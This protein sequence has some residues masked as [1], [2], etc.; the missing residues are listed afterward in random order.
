MADFV[1][2]RT[3]LEARGF[4]VEEFHTVA[5][6]KEHLQQTITQKTVAFGGSVG[7]TDMGLYEAL[8]PNN[9]VYW[10]AL[11]GPEVLK[12]AMSTN[13]YI[14]TAN[15]VAETGELINIDGTGNRV[16]STLF[17]HEDCYLIV[18]E[19]KI[20]PTYEDALWRA[21]NVVAPKNA[22]RLGKKT[23]CAI[24]GDQCYDCKSPER[25]CRGLVVLWKAVTS[26][27]THVVL[28]HESLG[29]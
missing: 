4:I 6:A 27:R 2:L 8:C 17:G 13:V 28:I 16:A 22:Q 23:P 5:Q 3:N 21:R 25:I 11:Q 29:Y 10:H 15:G 26:M 20:S 19:N 9:T 24:R 18:G 1:T 12:D 14:C 7:M